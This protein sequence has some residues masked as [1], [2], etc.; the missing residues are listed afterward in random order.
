MIEVVSL[1]VDGGF[2]LSEKILQKVGWKTGDK[3]T[4][5]VIGNELHMFSVEQAIQNLKEEVAKHV[6]PGMSMADELIRERRAE[7]ARE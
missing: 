4:V 1:D 6:P 2:S 3:L 7:A 5:E